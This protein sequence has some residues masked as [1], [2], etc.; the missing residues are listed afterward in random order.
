MKAV[1]V[2]PEAKEVK[3]VE[4]DEPDISSPTEVKLRVLEVGVCGTD[5][6]ICSFEYGTPPADSPYLLLGHESLSEVVETGA[7]VSRVKRGDLVVTSVRRPCPHQSCV[8]CRMGRQDF[9]FTGD[10]T[11]RGIKEQHGYMTEF[12]VD[13]EQYMN[14]VPAHLREIGVLVEPLTIA[15]KA[16]MQ[17]WQVQQRLPWECA[18]TTATNTGASTPTPTP[19]DEKGSQ[20]GHAVSCHRALVLGAG[21]V[22]LLGAMALVTAGFETHVYSREAAGSERA[23]LVE[24]FGAKYLSAET[25][26]VEQL[27][28]D[29]GGIDLVYEA[30][31]ASSLAFEVLKCLD[32]N[33]VFVFTGV[34][35]RKAPIAVDTDLLMRNLV[36]RNQV[37]FGTVNAGRD[38]FEAAIRDLEVF[39]TRWPQIVKS[40]ITARVPIEEHHDLLL[41]KAGGIKNVVKLA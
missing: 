36:L 37:V 32:M 3:L 8:A 7:A 20:R 18:P 13:D 35:G 23:Q 15:E 19:K 11:E 5:K 9:C 4:H 1:G 16:L 30:V 25:H 12:V 6:E 2:F 34:P 22:G 29:I 17:V 28:K 41:G 14:V 27:G 39:H 33:G 21:P 31:G 40:L 10:F 26:E 24:A 38:A